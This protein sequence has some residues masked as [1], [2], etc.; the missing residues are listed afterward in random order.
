MAYFYNTSLISL[1]KIPIQNNEYFSFVLS[2]LK[3]FGKFH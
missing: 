1:I 2:V 3:N